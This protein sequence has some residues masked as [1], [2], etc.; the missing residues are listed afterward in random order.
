MKKMKKL[1]KLA[2]VLLTVAL[3]VSG[4]GGAAG[5]KEDTKK[6]TK[7]GAEKGEVKIG[8]EFFD[9]TMPLGVDIKE[10][11]DYASDAVGCEIQYVSNNWDA[12]KAM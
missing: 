11:L 7:S 1:E 12:E 8:A 3:F 6:E 4:C 10:M 9:W 5:S 2:A